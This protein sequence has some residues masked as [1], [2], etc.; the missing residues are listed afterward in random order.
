[1]TPLIPSTAHTL[2]FKSTII[3]AANNTTVLSIARNHITEVI[4]AELPYFI[5]IDIQINAVNALKLAYI[6]FIECQPDQ[7][8]HDITCTILGYDSVLLEE[9]EFE[10]GFWWNDN[11]EQQ[12]DYHTDCKMEIVPYTAD[13]P[14]DEDWRY[15]LI[16]WCEYFT[17][18]LEK[19]RRRHMNMAIADD[20]ERLKLENSILRFLL[21]PKKF[22]QI[23][24]SN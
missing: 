22:R 12:G 5:N 17:S 7:D 20:P 14:D 21:E 16:E 10:P 1:M 23:A 9:T 2:R 3:N 4:K 8:P 13:I 19:L 11:N 6:A 15:E 24:F 18:E